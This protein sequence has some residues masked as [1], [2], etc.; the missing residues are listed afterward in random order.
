MAE[1]EGLFYITYSHARSKLL[2]VAL[3]IEPMFE[4]FLHEKKIARN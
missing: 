2:R 4:S 3:F 1:G